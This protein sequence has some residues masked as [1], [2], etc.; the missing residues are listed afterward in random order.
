MAEQLAHGIQV[1]APLHES[2]R[3]MVPQIMPAE[4]LDLGGL[5]RCLPGLVN[6]EN[7]KDGIRAS[8]L[9]PPP[10]QNVECLGVQWNVSSLSALGVATSN[11]EQALLEVHVGPG[12]LSQFAPAHA[13]IHRQHHH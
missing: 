7:G 11:S 2:R 6:A 5:Q 12:D 1:N 4:A 3:E 8:T 10:V 13:R 9:S